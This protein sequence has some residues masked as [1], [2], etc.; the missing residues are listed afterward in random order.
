LGQLFVAEPVAA[1]HGQP[2]VI[3]DESPPATLGGGRVLQP[4]ARRIRRR[5]AHARALLGRLADP[6]PS[7]RVVAALAGQGLKS[8]TERTLCRDTGLAIGE[9]AEALARLSG[10]GTLV[11]LSL[12]PRRSVRLLA[13]VVAELEDRLL[14]A[15]GRLH[16]ERPRQSAIGRARVAAALADLNN[17]A[18]VAAL[19]DRLKAQGKV[20]ADARTVALVGHEPKLSQGER[21]LKAE[22]AEAYRDGGLSP[23]DPSTWTNAPGPRAAIV[24][25]LFALL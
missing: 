16:A 2:F 23:P 6:D 18:L 19:I 4:V 10:S 20:V 12:G 22:I 3:R 14:R 21:R 11:E 17:D 7:R 24:P 25:E 15:L 1:V 9:A 5:D 8:W 13:E